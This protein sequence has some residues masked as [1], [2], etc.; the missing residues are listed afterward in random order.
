MHS[1]SNKINTGW[2]LRILLLIAAASNIPLMA[3]EQPAFF[4]YLRQTNP[5]PALIAYNPSNIN[6]DDMHLSAEQL[7]A[8]VQKDLTCL[9]SGFNGLVLYNYNPEITPIVVEQA[10]QSGF[11]GILLGV[12]DVKSEQEL[13]GTVALINKYRDKAAFAVVIGN[14]GLNDNRYTLA[15]VKTAHT[16]LIAA[17][18]DRMRIPLTTSEPMAG[19]G[20]ADLRLFGD[21]L[22][23]NIHPAID[24][25][26]LAPADAVDWVQG[27]AKV[28]AQFAKKPVF[29]KETGLPNGGDAAFTPA[30]QFEFWKMLRDKG[31]L[32]ETTGLPGAWI[33]LAAVFEA[34]DSPWKAAKSGNP[35]EGRWGLMD[36]QLGAYPAFGVFAGNLNKCKSEQ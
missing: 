1:K 10:L 11:R 22:A 25:K 21:F 26:E 27:R 12:W 17:G 15:D 35:I 8:H 36:E 31:P 4:D 34:F 28:L 7:A 20:L 18:L 29:V 33:S 24:R 16:K 30:R 13:S 2:L 9:K 32:L 23:P 5:P 3:A 14:E 6:P 19:Y